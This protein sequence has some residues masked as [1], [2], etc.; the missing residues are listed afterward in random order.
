M[1]GRRRNGSW[2][3]KPAPAALKVDRKKLPRTFNR[4]PAPWLQP[5][6]DLPELSAQS[7][8]SLRRDVLNLSREDAARVLR[9]RRNTIWDWE[10]GTRRPPFSAYLA[11][12]CLADS[13][14]RSNLPIDPATDLSAPDPAQLAAKLVPDASLGYRG[15]VLHM[16]ARM[17]AFSS[18]YNAAWHVRNSW[19][20]PTMRQQESVW[21]LVNEMVRELRNCADFEALLY[22]LADALTLS[23]QGVPW[24][25][26]SERAYKRTRMEK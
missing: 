24:K 19:F 8:L 16:Q 21:R 14:R 12:R 9:V 25:D 20:G 5:I 7:M 11:L 1:Q 18:V 23:P 22:A 6:F 2:K 15:R 26:D 4:K 3:E 10:T 13:V 17:Q